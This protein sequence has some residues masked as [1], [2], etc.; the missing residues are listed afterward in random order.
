[1]LSH[2]KRGHQ[3]GL[4]RC[5]DAHDMN[6]E[7]ACLTWLGLLSDL[8]KVFSQAQITSDLEVGPT[9]VFILDESEAIRKSATWDGALT[10]SFQRR[11]P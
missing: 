3:L 9:P 7:R 11:R 10:S 2:R 8:S 1:M 4:P 6:V 5:S